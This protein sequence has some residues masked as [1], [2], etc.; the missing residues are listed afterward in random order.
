MSSRIA[1][2]LI[3]LAVAALGGSWF[4]LKDEGKSSPTAVKLGQTLFP[5]L[6]AE[7]IAS[8]VVAAPDGTLT[9]AK[10]ED[11]WVIVEQGGFPADIDRVTE[12]VVKA[13]ELKTG[14]SEPIAEK[15]R[16]RML[17]GPPGKGEGAAT[18]VAFKDKDGKVLAEL[19]VGKKYFRNE[20]A[21]DP[22]KALGDGRFVM[23]AS[24][25][26]RVIVV[27]DPLRQASIKPVDW[28]AREGFGIE[29]VKTLD[30]KVAEGGY[31]LAREV[32]D[33]NF[34]L[35][36]KGGELDPFKASGAA[37]A[38]GRLELE[39][40]GPKEAEAGF[41]KGSQIVATTF[42]GLTY[43]MKVGALAKD[44]YPV[45]VSVEGTPTRAPKPA[46]AKP[47]EKAEDKDKREKAA[48]DEVKRFTERV[49]REKSLAPFVVLVAKNKLDEVLK[50]RDDFL[51]KEEKK[52][53]DK[54]DGARKDDKKGAKK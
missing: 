38:L 36:G 15:E 23:L 2:I 20:P 28:I 25:T 47:D 6:Q 19:L 35:D 49:A 43:T 21:G 13:I 33:G 32:P 4:L 14:Q 8:I 16:A 26:T 9:L 11:R 48:A 37:L 41:D 29:N 42:D 5:Q 7:A 45:Q 39:D 34:V 3:I 12:L 27:S 24:D 54:K 51:K 40:L 22:T 1:A 30:V 46:P 18:S 31:K 52:D 10:K 44:R 50:K 17:L 53:G